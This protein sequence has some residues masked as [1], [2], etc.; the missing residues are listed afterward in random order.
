MHLISTPDAQ[1]ILQDVN[2]QVPT[3]D[4]QRI[5]DYPWW[6][7]WEAQMVIIALFNGCIWLFITL[8]FQLLLHFSDVWLAIVPGS[9][10]ILTAVLMIF[11]KG[12]AQ[13]E[14]PERR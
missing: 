3:K 6:E 13:G 2:G 11:M 1:F 5:P 9:A 7:A 10:T 14:N 4:V 8:F 12:A